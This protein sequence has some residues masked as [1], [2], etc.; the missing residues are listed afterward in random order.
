M[1]TRPHPFL[2]R[3]AP[4]TSLLASLATCLL[5]FTP[6][7]VAANTNLSVAVEAVVQ[8]GASANLNVDE[9]AAGYLHV[10]YSAALD[11]SRKT[12]LQF[13]LTGVNPAP[14]Q[15]ATLTVYFTASNLQRVKLWGLKQSYPGFSSSVTWNTAQA[16][17]T[18]SN[19]LLSSGSFTASQI[20]ADVLIPLS[21][22][23]PYT[24]SIPR[25]GDFLFSNQVTLVLT[26]AA[27][28]SNN[29]GGL[30]LQR[31]QATL[32]L[33]GSAPTN[34]NYDVYLIAG[35]SNADG[36]GATGDLTNGLAAWQSPQADV[37]IYYANP[38][39]LDPLNP[40]YNTGWSVLAPGFSVPP[41]FSGPLP[42]SKF[43]PELSFART[44]ADAA[45][46]RRLALI[47]VTQGGT[48]L[49]NDWN[50]ASGYL[51]ATF[52][53]ITRTALQ[54]LT[55]EGAR[56]TLRGL[57]WHQGE[58]DGSVATEVYQ[59]M[60]TNFINAVRRD[61]GVTN[62]PVVV[63]ELATN[64]SVTVRQAQFNVAEIMPYVGFASSS[65]L[66]TLVANDPHFT[67]TSQLTMG[68]RMAAALEIPPLTLSNASLVGTNLLVTATG[69]A[70]ATCWL[71]ATTN[72]TGPPGSWT[73]VA[74]NTFDAS[75]Q[76]PFV[77]PLRPDAAAL[78]LR[79]KPE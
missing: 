2:H 59:S 10:K 27:D 49:S 38:I 63:G 19:D 1:N 14:D 50:P 15:G 70:R 35:Q 61:L 57:V 36:R 25:L 60:L 40:T 64:R 55:N 58:S 51:Y 68:Q 77:Q 20:G 66:P 11:L 47:K 3:Y 7:V 6:G 65:N 76:T 48:S 34:S 39:N 23:N 31:G 72:L 5:V 22:T 18:N 37:R 17:N 73:A 62:L 26:G 9:A 78:F 28:A 52:T 75:G 46:N 56:Y 24:F 41:G 16:N 33:N 74:T 8:G 12:Y 4:A 30:R 42:S 67:A 53:N 44:L 69:L 79:L 71:E 21:G 29:A 13:D 54:A 45:P 32:T 43:G